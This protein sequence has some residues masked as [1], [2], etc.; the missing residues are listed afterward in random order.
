MTP[1]FTPT[2]TP[3]FLVGPEPYFC[4][5]LI[6]RGFGGCSSAR[7]T[8]VSFH[9][10]KHDSDGSPSAGKGWRP[11]QDA[12]L[13]IRSA[14][15]RGPKRESCLK[16]LGEGAKGILAHVERESPKSLLHQCKPPLVSVQQA[17]GPHAPKHLFHPLLTNWTIFAFRFGALKQALQV[18]RPA[19]CWAST[20]QQKVSCRKHVSGNEPESE[21]PEPPRKTANG[22]FQRRNLCW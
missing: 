8:Q 10:L 9:L 13:E 4:R 14:C 17:F 12:G 1:T 15:Y 16:C 7:T 2:L 5:I 20:F 18:S 19:P 22:I 11:K 6:L 21:T 3:T